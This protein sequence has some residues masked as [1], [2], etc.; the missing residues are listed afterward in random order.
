MPSGPQGGGPTTVDSATTLSKL[1]AGTSGIRPAGAGVRN[2]GRAD[3][4]ATWV[5]P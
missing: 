5:G 4:P 2:L 3:V 1:E